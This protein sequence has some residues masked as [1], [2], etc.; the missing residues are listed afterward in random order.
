MPASLPAQKHLPLFKSTLKTNKTL[1]TPG[2][3]GFEGSWEAEEMLGK[4]EG[5]AE[6]AAGA[7]PVGRSRR[8]G[9]NLQGVSGRITKDADRMFSTRVI[10][11]DPV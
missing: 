5:E 1:K 8:S 7:S 3:V 2:F 11:T 4:G 9:W 10:K 6:T